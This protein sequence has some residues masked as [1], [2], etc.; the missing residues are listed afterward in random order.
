MLQSAY[1]RFRLPLPLGS[2]YSLLSQSLRWVGR[3]RHLLKNPWEKQIYKIRN[4]GRKSEESEVAVKRIR[5]RTG[6]EQGKDGSSKKDGSRKNARMSSKANGRDKQKG[7]WRKT[8]ATFRGPKD[9]TSKRTVRE[10][11][12]RISSTGEKDGSSKKDGSRKRPHFEMEE[13][14]TGQEKGR[15]EKTPALFRWEKKGRVNKKDEARK[16]PCF[17]NG[18]KRTGQEKLNTKTRYL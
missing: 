18:E 1:K 8:P 9:G 14:R 15:V 7:G 5:K 10:E 11:N 2:L 17:F 6:R 12:T 3:R 4:R 16:N 13:Q